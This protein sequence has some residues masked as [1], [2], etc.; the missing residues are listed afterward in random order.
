[1]SLSRPSLII[2]GGSLL[3]AGLVILQV[4]LFLTLQRDAKDSRDWV[5]HSVAVLDETE[6]LLSKMK[7]NE[8]AERNFLL[9]GQ[10]HFLGPFRVALGL[11]ASGFGRD[12]LMALDQ[13]DLVAVLGS[14]QELTHDNM[15]QQVKIAELRHAIDIKT[16]RSLERISMVLREKTTLTGAAAI[17]P[18]DLELAARARN[19]VAEIIVYEQSLLSARNATDNADESRL[20]SFIAIAAIATYAVLAVMLLLV[21]ASVRRLRSKT[22]QLAAQE[23]YFRAAAEGGLAAFFLFQREPNASGE[24]D[25][26]LEY[27]NS[28]AANLV[29]MPLSEAY[30]RPV[31][32]MIKTLQRLHEDPQ[33]RYLKAMAE[34]VTQ[35]SEYQVKGGPLAGRYFQEQVVPLPDGIAISCRDITERKQIETIKRD[36]ISVVSHE[37]RTPLTAIRGSLSLIVGGAVGNVS[38]EISSLLR[39][40]YNNCERLVRLIND[41]LDIEKIEAGRTPFH[42][43]PLSLATCLRQAIEQNASIAEKFYVNL[44]LSAPA[45][46]RDITAMADPDRLMQIMTNLLSN[47]IKFSPPNGIVTIGFSRADGMARVTVH[48]NGLGIPKAFRSQ[49]FQKFA[50]ADGSASREKGGTGLGLSIVKAIVEE[51]GGTIGFDSRE[52]E[53]TT[54]FFTLP[55]AQQAIEQTNP[56]PP[57]MRENGEHGDRILICEDEADIANFLKMALERAGFA[58]DIA[59]DAASALALLR[60]RPYRA[61]T[62]DLMLPDKCGITLLRDIR[63]DANLASLPVVVVSAKAEGGRRLLKGDAIGMAGWMSKPIDTARLINI[64]Q[65]TIGT[66]GPC[67]ILHVEDEPDIHEVLRRALGG[68]IEVVVAPTLAEARRL[69]AAQHFDLVILDVGLPD[70]NGLDLLSVLGTGRQ[71]PIPV[72]LFTAQ[73]I[74]HEVATEVA[75]IMTKSKTS[76]EKLLQTIR[77]LI[78]AAQQKADQP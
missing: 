35:E 12:R 38:T 70:G 1:M 22:R 37:L 39:I 31:G 45:D 32:T 74:P 7:D 49:V 9:T 14:L 33:D 27:M 5:A 66:D 72:M 58:S 23:S 52:G 30:T 51:L 11:G 48:D 76:E 26:S 62:L 4:T 65:A 8:L 43:R 67:R 57:E 36:F 44:L 29:G 41:I 69:L 47:A 21:I 63:A 24:M 68:N 20:T 6:T 34:Q 46:D 40:A 2:L 77:H 16:A 15:F 61:M 3:L 50:Q 13:R 19:L 10:V 73:E 78:P 53:G 17:E 28:L 64:L 42:V 71:F 60:T 56:P 18:I 25:F 54:F 59:P 55:L 75:A